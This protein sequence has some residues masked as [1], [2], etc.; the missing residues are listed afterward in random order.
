MSPSPSPKQ[1]VP[2]G[3]KEQQTTISNAR[4][5]RVPYQRRPFDSPSNPTSLS[6][7]DY[8]GLPSSPPSSSSS[9]SSS[10]SSDPD[11]VVTLEFLRSLQY[12]TPGTPMA[13]P[14]SLPESHGSARRRSKPLVKSQPSP[15]RPPH[16]VTM[17]ALQQPEAFAYRYCRYPGCD[18]RFADKR[19]TERHRL[20]HL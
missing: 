3:K 14:S 18:K 19:T 13:G 5:R 12:G 9:T 2:G 17:N 16:N 1:R 11:D 10:I 6:R 4:T 15:S 20:T 8:S 7:S